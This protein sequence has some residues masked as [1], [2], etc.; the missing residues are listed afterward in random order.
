MINNIYIFGTGRWS[1]E[2]IQYISK[3]KNYKIFVISK[4]KHLKLWVK[5]NKLRDV[6]FFKSTS[7]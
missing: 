7:N 2:F 6:F 1:Q 3:S 5:K 4:K